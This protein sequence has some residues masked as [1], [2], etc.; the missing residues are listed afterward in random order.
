MQTSMR[1]AAYNEDVLSEAFDKATTETCFWLPTL[2]PD[3]SQAWSGLIEEGDNETYWD[4]YKVR[5]QKQ[6]ETE[7]I[8]VVVDRLQESFPETSPYIMKKTCSG[9]EKLTQDAT[10]FFLKD[11]SQAHTTVAAL[12]EWVGQDEAPFPT[13]KQKAEFVRDC[14]RLYEKCGGHREVH[15]V[16]S[17]LSRIIAV[18]F[19]GY[20]NNGS[21]GLCLVKTPAYA[22]DHVRT[23]LTQFAFANPSDLGFE[24]MSEAH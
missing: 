16:I 2:Q 11:R 17:D 19:D 15:G 18:R 14:A 10:L 13:K 1:L 21:G 6:T 4:S 20:D 5:D 8:Q 3:Q 24:R 23:I 7:V 9:W 12:F 22:G